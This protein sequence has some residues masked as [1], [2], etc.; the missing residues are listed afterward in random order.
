MILTKDDM[1]AKLDPFESVE[2]HLLRTGLICKI[3]CTKTSLKSVFKVLVDN[4]DG[5]SEE[6]LLNLVCYIV[7]MH[8]IGKVSPFF[9][10][11]DKN[12]KK[13]YKD[14]GYFEKYLLNNFR[15]EI[16]SS[17]YLKDYLY[18][19]GVADSKLIKSFC[20]VISNHHNKNINKEVP[21]E[22][23][24]NKNV[25]KNIID[26]IEFNIYNKFNF[27]F[28]FFRVTHFDIFFSYLLG[29]LIICDW[30]S[31]GELSILDL[32]NDNIEYDI[33]IKLI[34]LGFGS[35]NV[36]WHSYTYDR[37]L[38]IK[39]L[40]LNNMQLWIQNNIHVINKSNL[41]FIESSTGS[42]KTSASLFTAFNLMNTNSGFYYALPMQTM[43]NS[44]Y[45][46]LKSIFDL[47]NL[48]LTLLHGNRFL[49][50]DIR[51]RNNS[52]ILNDD[53]IIEVSDYLFESSRLGLFNQYI[54]GTIDQLLYSILPNK[55]FILRLLS[56]AGKVLILDEVHMYDVYTSL[57][58]ERLLSWC[59]P[60]NIKIIIL[61]A[62]LSKD[63]KERYINAYSGKKVNLL[64][65]F[66][67][68][69]TCVGDSGTVEYPILDSNINKYYDL[70]IL[71][72][73]LDIKSQAEN[74]NRLYNNKNNIIVYK[75]TVSEAQELYKYCKN[76]GIENI[77]LLHSKFKLCDRREKEKLILKYF[78]KDIS[79][80]PESYVV[81]STQVLEASLDLDFDVCFTDICPFD[82]LLQRLGRQGRFNR[83]V[84][85]INYGEVYIFYTDML[86]DSLSSY[87]YSPF[88]L[89]NTYNYLLDKNKLI[90]PI[91]IRDGIEKIY[92]FNIDNY[93]LYLKKLSDDDIKKTK[94][95]ISSL[96]IP[97]IEAFNILPDDS[98]FYNEEKGYYSSRYNNDNVNLVI[99]DN[100]EE[101]DNDTLDLKNYMINSFSY[102]LNNLNLDFLEKF[103]YFYI[104][105]LNH[106]KL[107]VDQNIIYNYNKEIGF[108]VEVL[109]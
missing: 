41:I 53:E 7:S 15:H 21:Q 37:I 106:G 57:L 2:S 43:V 39:D 22:I 91:M 104:L 75:N 82:I 67:P 97:N 98:L 107:V 92:K 8:D 28:N 20:D 17:F 18:K 86:E 85:S 48:N 94:A 24:K 50:E 69:I 108:F 101:V 59:S 99:L 84:K 25:W 80:R 44:K 55:F 105:K 103:K 52:Y 81:I 88:L 13:K 42:G 70:K 65:E 27:D 78:G 87:I 58:I 102:N 100:I 1:W 96:S 34:S 68:L 72:N 16:Q 26:D 56:L 61:S 60:L 46:E 40:K 33:Y 66:Y 89:K 31:S 54:V 10:Q 47:E 29:L 62:T 93:D 14:N 38:N 45:L 77:I 63:L 109:R 36:D 76:L 71:S 64:N 73:L 9:Q 19:H 79:N 30:L 11:K 95:I 23:K 12:I 74:I 49:F 90:I 51:E 3:A 6:N 4:C 83:K 5:I 32:N 35:N